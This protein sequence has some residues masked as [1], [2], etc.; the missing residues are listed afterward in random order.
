[1]SWSPDPATWQILGSTA[2]NAIK[3][4]ITATD[5]ADTAHH[6][7]Y[8]AVAAQQTEG[9]PDNLIDVFRVDTATG[10]RDTAWDAQHVPLKPSS[11]TGAFSGIFPVDLKINDGRVVLAWSSG[12]LNG[13]YEGALSEWSVATGQPIPF[14]GAGF[15]KASDGSWMW[16]QGFWTDGLKFRPNAIDVQDDGKIVLVGKRF[17][18][19]PNQQNIGGGIWRLNADGSR[20]TTFGSGGLYPQTGVSEFMSVTHIGSTVYA[21]ARGSNVEP[22]RALIVKLTS[23]GVPDASFSGGPWTGWVDPY[24]TGSTPY[25]NYDVQGWWPKLLGTNTDKT[26]LLMGANVDIATGGSPNTGSDFTALSPV[27]GSFD[28]SFG[29]GGSGHFLFAMGGSLSYDPASLRTA[30]TGS[31][32]FRPAFV[33]DNQGTQI[34]YVPDPLYSNTQAN[35]YRDS[36]YWPGAIFLSTDTLLFVEPNATDG[37]ALLGYELTY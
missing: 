27:N 28:S 17:G 18:Y 25:P 12:Q 7:Q 14:T 3:Y 22:G 20:D 5:P 15:T 29:P 31:G 33:F 35:P 37:H 21:A 30:V 23:A 8:F 9:S 2:T 36:G 10:A 16:M 19:A 11:G 6:Y 1:M 4:A 32:A 34:A 13:T 24:P 26:K